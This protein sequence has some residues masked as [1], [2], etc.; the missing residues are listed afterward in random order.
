MR[1]NAMDCDKVKTELYPEAPKPSL[2]IRS[3]F[4]G[5]YV[6]RSWPYHGWDASKSMI[7]HSSQAWLRRMAAMS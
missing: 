4:P 6:V 7:A 3:P 5:A 1:Q 2:E